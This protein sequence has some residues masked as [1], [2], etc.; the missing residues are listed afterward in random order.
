MNKPYDNPEFYLC[1][2]DD[3]ALVQEGKDLTKVMG[4]VRDTSP[5]H[6][7][8]CSESGEGGVRL[9][10]AEKEPP[11]YIKENSEPRE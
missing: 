7:L 6:C 10:R 4:L 8:S 2:S 11:F 3:E 1:C 5:F 9:G